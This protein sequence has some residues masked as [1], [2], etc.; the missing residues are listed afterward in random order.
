MDQELTEKEK[1]ILIEIMFHADQNG[2]GYKAT[3]ARYWSYMKD[4]ERGKEFNRNYNNLYAK[5]MNNK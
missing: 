2:N 1:D 3:K 5:I 4:H